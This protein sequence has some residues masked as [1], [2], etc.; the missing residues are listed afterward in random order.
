VG[1]LCKTYVRMARENGPGNPIV[2]LESSTYKHPEYGRVYKPVLKVV[3]WEKPD[4]VKEKKALPPKEEAKK[5]PAKEE[6]KKPA[7]KG[8]TK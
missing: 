5:A 4:D 1:D 8:K 7:A 2:V 3:G 6:A